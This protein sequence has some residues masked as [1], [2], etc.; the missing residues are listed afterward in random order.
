MLNESG[1]SAP[2]TAALPQFE[3]CFNFRDLGG[4]TNAD[5]RVVR[6]GHVF[7]SGS[8]HRMTEADRAVL[9]RLG[10]TTV[11]D[12]RRPDEVARHPPPTG[13]G[14]VR[15]LPLEIEEPPTPRE[16]LGPVPD[17][18][19][20]EYLELA[21]ADAGRGAI[22]ASFR[23]IAD[24]GQ[25]V[26]I[27]CYAGKD[28]TGIVAA[29]LL[30]SLGVDDAAIVADYTASDA[31]IEPSLAYAERH[32]SEWARLIERLP[33]RVLRSHPDGIVTLLAG[34]R[35]QFGSIRSYL[36]EI[37]A[38]GDCLSRLEAKLLR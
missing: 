20:E 8:L 5:G 33:P 4:H 37:G 38:R 10:V 25:R 16:P 13:I 12:L 1:R 23:V 35:R 19:G 14:A 2:S 28:R 36:H 7:R 34:L 21:T 18:L 3:A 24:P 22:A 29:L 11:V 32:D 9:A 31:A 30:A 6:N 17:H 26:V 27:H 15:H